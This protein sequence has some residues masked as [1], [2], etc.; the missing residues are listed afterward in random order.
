[1]KRLLLPLLAA[2]ALPTSVN[3]EVEVSENIHNRCKDAKDYVGC[4]QIMTGE[5]SIGSGDG[6][7]EIVRKDKTLILFNPLAIS[8]MEVREEYGRYLKYEYLQIG[9]STL[10][11]EVIADCKDYTADW[12]GGIGGWRDLR[13][14]K[15]DSSIEAKNILDEFCPQMSKIVEETTSGERKSFSYPKITSS[16]GGYI[17]TSG[18]GAAA[19]NAQLQN[20]LNIQKLQH[21]NQMQRTPPQYRGTVGM[22]YW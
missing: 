9:N 1:M 17:D 11:W 12:K 3:A 6:T 21:L 10:L 20:Q 14:S 4:V 16:G 8:A 18:A 7:R 19:R 13:T 15:R 2:L 22:P 5:K